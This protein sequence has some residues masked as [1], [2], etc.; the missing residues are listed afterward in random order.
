MRKKDP[1]RIPG[2][3]EIALISVL[4]RSF[5]LCAILVHQLLD[6]L[7]GIKKVADG[8]IMVEGIDDISNI[9]AHIAVDIPL[10][11]KELR[12]LIYKVCCK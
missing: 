4:F 12:C 9:L 7:T 2:S 10:T 6:T 3:S 11:F 5:C 8:S 1:G